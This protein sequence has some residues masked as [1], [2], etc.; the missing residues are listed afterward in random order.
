MKKISL[1]KKN[2]FHSFAQSIDCG[3]TLELPR[4]GGSNKYP[5]SMFRSKN[6]THVYPCKTHF[7]YLKVGYKGVYISRTCFPD[8]KKCVYGGGVLY[9]QHVSREKKVPISCAVTDHYENLPLLYFYAPNF[10]RS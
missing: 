7:Y 1:E 6:K 10:G 5:Q 2:I 4:R 8:D 9:N 3:Y